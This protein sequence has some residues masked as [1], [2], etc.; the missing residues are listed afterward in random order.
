[1]HENFETALNSDLAYGEVKIL[2]KIY[3]FRCC[4]LTNK[5]TTLIKLLD[6]LD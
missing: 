2:C 4:V 5:P 1:M 6:Y 3:I